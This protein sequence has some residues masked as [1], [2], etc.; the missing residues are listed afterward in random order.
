MSAAEILFVLFY[1]MLA[2]GAVATIV[3][4]DRRAPALMALFG[5]AAGGLLVAAGVLVLGWSE[6]V[7]FTLWSLPSLGRLHLAVDRLSALFLIVAGLVFLP[8]S[9]FSAG[10][11][12][13]FAGRYSLKAMGIHYYALFASIALLL[14]TD[15]LLLF[16]LAWEAM[17]I[18]AYLL[19]NFD[20]EREQTRGAAYLFFAMA[21]AGTAAVV[22]AFVLLA[23]AAHSFDF[24]PIREIAGSLGAG[25]RW[26][27]FLLSFFGFG[28]KA[29]IVPVNTWL[30]RAHPAAPANVSAILSA[31]VLN[32]GLYGMLRTNGDLL[33]LS[34]VTPGVIVLVVGALTALVGIL[35]ATTAN[36]LK[37]MLAHSS[38]ENIGIVVAGFGGAFVFGAAGRPDLA[39]IL[40]VAAVY[41]MTNHSLYKSLLF[42]SAGSIDEAVGTRDLDRLGGLARF[43]PLT[44][45]F[46]LVGALS[47]SAI[48]PFNGFVSEWLTLQGILRSAELASRGVKIAFVL[49]GAGLALTAALAI[50]CFVKA[51]AMGFLGL[52]RTQAVRQARERRAITIFSLG[53]PALLSLALGILPTYVVP[54]LDRAVR[55][56]L[57]QA[58]ATGQLVPPFFS[59]SPAHSELPPA[60]VADF[61][62]IG[63]QIGQTILP[64]RGLV[65]MHRGGADQHVVFAMSPSYMVVLLLL[66][67]GA[68]YLGVRLA[69]RKRAMRRAAR[70]DGGLHRLLPEM[71]YT[72]TGF[73]SPVRVIF[74]AIF[75]PRAAEDVRETV[76]VHF[77]TAI[78]RRYEEVHVV[79]R[80]FIHP[81]T[82][83]AR[84][85]S[86]TLARMHNGKINTYVIYV[87]LTLAV[88]VLVAWLA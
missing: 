20:H 88:F 82:H 11:A 27:V 28:V 22:V 5:A 40:F 44:S 58:S 59:G 61:H 26:A 52:P 87:L 50:T 65:V 6:R 70:W 74:R 55:P 60:F 38:I 84:W 9:L 24:A 8:V 72:A 13:R 79:S 33:P 29:G 51:F 75:R 1:V 77:R 62:N 19:V 54:L 45:I 64:G 12:L 37:T 14:S 49:A 36:D 56:A 21:E 23:N 17:T 18:F 68:T 47:I 7:E 63:A 16:L 2:A 46:F 81:V 71:T 4:G 39:A 80:L 86:D 69:T 30:P 25:T 85:L 31:V 76:S 83:A 67:G 53:I 34:T 32:M 15:S 3:A 10:Y 78:R 48:P 57:V 73:S 43:M 35:Y 42:M 66:L 41:H